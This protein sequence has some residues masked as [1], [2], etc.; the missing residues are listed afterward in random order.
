M[1]ALIQAIHRIINEASGHV[2]T[3]Q[4]DTNIMISRAADEH[5]A[6]VIRHQPDSVA[7]G[8]FLGQGFAEMQCLRYQSLEP[9]TFNS[10]TMLSLH[11]P[12]DLLSAN[13]E[14]PV[15]LHQLFRAR[16]NFEDLENTI[17]ER[18]PPVTQRISFA[19]VPFR[20]PVRQR[21]TIARAPAY[22]II[23]L[24]RWSA[25]DDGSYEKIKHPIDLGDGG[26]DLHEYIYI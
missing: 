19:P 6:A 24:L 5:W 18:C 10:L 14:W 4:Y 26:I 3:N 8:P 1:L 16:F 2:S 9:R 15:F 13:A 20:G 7:D 17:C 21:Y 22:L 12:P 25:I 11:I 23:H